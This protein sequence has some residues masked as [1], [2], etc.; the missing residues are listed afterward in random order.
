MTLRA[1]VIWIDCGRP[2]G[3]AG[4][5]VKEKNWLEAERQI[6][7]EV[8]ARAFTIWNQQG[9]P[10]GAAGEAVRE[11]NMRA[12][13]SPTAEGNRRRDHRIDIQLTS[14]PFGWHELTATRR[15]QSAK[16]GPCTAHEPSRSPCA[17]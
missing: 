6:L 15:A 3:R 8:K 16:Q 9:C 1:Y 17:D 7:D 10:A 5:L 4:E 13:R 12:G 2:K 14:L 11:K